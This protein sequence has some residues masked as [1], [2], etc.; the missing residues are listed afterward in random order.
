MSRAGLMFETCTGL[1]MK[2]INK[3]SV[4]CWFI[5]YGYITVQGQQNIKKVTKTVCTITFTKLQNRP[6]KS[7]WSKPQSEKANPKDQ[8]LCDMLIFSHIIIKFHAFYHCC[9]HSPPAVLSQA[10]SHVKVQTSLDC[11]CVCANTGKTC[12]SQ[13]TRIYSKQLCSHY[14]SSKA[15]SCAVQQLKTGSA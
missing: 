4:S 9:V 5:L 10:H 8:V 3:N 15:N 12:G 13:L 1:L 6:T 2:L 11:I 7:Q 14:R